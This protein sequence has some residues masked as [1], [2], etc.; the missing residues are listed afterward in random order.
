MKK[1]K[2]GLLITGVVLLLSVATINTTVLAT[3]TA[4]TN[5]EISFEPGTLSLDSVGNIYFGSHTIDGSTTVFKKTT[6]SLM[7]VSDA[8]GSGAGWR[9]TVSLS[10][11]KNTLGVDS[12]PGATIRFMDAHAT[13]LAEA[14]VMSSTITLNP[15]NTPVLVAEAVSGTGRGQWDLKVDANKAEIEV[16]VA[17]QAVS[18]YKAVMNWTLSDLP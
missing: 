15:D 7:Q 12:L 8:R 3:N 9:L 1:F 18:T 10:P 2:L 5:A 13:G 4:T 14:P 6:Q 16:P 17:Q 11:F